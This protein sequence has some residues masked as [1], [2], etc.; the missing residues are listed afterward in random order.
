M[1]NLNDAFDGKDP[2]FMDGLFPDEDWRAKIAEARRHEIDWGWF[3]DV[4][5]PHGMLMDVHPVYRKKTGLVRRDEDLPYAIL[6]SVALGLIRSSEPD[7]VLNSDG[8]IIHYWIFLNGNAPD[9]V[10]M[11]S[12]RVEGAE[13]TEA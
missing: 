2:E 10:L 4:F 11:C 12:N 7:A 9:D 13:A 8:E 3:W 5:A 6:K 1:T